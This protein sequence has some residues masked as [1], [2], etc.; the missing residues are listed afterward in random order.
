MR[1]LKLYFY[2]LLV[3]LFVIFIIQNYYTLT[4][5]VAFRF[6][7]GFVSLVSI[8]LPLF[9]VP[10]LFFFCGLFLATLIGW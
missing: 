2:G 6:N 9:L 8:P 7:L 4:Y 5:N 3:L 1:T 10:P